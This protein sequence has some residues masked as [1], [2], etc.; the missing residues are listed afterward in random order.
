MTLKL[1][2]GLRDA[3]VATGSLKGTLDG[4]VMRFYDGVVPASADAAIT[5]TM[6]VE[7]TLN[8]DGAT[9][10]TYEAVTGSGYARKTAA[11]VWSGTVAATGTI[12]HARFC[13]IA[14]DGTLS[15]T[16]VRLQFER[17]DMALSVETP[18]QGETYDVD[19][20]NLILPES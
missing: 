5:G 7:M 11:E 8:A 1:S 13:A 17:S 12:T 3:L 16:A 9:G 10:L 20:F 19:F 6:L 2:T 18:T 15:T 14:D 4:M